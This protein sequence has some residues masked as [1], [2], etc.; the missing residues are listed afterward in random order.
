[1]LA[2]LKKPISNQIKSQIEI[3]RKD[4]D[5]DFQEEVVELLAS[6]AVD[7]FGGSASDYS[8]KSRL[9]EDIHAKSVNIVQFSA[10][11]EDEYEVEVPYMELAKCK[12]FEEMADYVDRLLSM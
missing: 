11:L 6:K 1:M 9:G 10:A 12:T 2:R 4:Y 5:M 8:A 3:D 7:M